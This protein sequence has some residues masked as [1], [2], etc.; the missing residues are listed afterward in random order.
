VQQALAQCAAGGAASSVGGNILP[1]MKLVDVKPIY[2]DALKASGISGIVTL[3]AVIGTDGLVRDVQAISG[4][5]PDLEAAA[6]TAVREWEFSP[7]LLNCQA[8]DVA[9]RVTVNFA[10][11]Q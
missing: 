3:E 5:H 1:P 2:P 11:E 4:P 10:A 6:A 8:I 9:M 7:T